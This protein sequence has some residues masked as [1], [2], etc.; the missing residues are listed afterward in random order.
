MLLQAGIPFGREFRAYTGEGGELCAMRKIQTHHGTTV[1][2]EK[3][4]SG[5][6]LVLVHGAFSDHRSNWEYVMPF[7]A[8]WFTVYAIARRGRGET[9]ASQGHRIEDEFQDVASVIGTIGKPVFLV[10]HS[11]GAHVALGAAA[12]IPE[13]VKR[14]VLYEAPLP[15]LFGK[16]VLEPIVR[17][18]EAGDWD[19]FCFHFFRDLLEVPQEEMEALRESSHWTPIRSDAEASLQ[20][21]RALSVYD[22][23]PERFRKLDMPVLLQYGSESARE[24]YVTQALARILEQAETQE[25][26]GQAHEG[27]TT[28]PGLYLKKLISFLAQ[29]SQAVA[30]R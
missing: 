27:M 17:R 14:L 16:E 6:P 25:L 18:A 28:A 3:L 19:G 11:Y 21:L 20:D 9:S 26:E 30:T 24:L 4:G 12:L 10:G 1:S 7:L 5:P 29:S 13:M 15:S 2:Y 8:G 22:F 23:R